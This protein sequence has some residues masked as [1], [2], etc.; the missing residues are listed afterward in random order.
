MA[1][2]KLTKTAILEGVWIGEL[3]GGEPGVR[4]ELE[5]THQDRPVPG[6]ELAPGQGDAGVWTLRIPI[7]ATVLT[8]GVQVVLI[9]DRKSGLCLDS[10]A[11][12]TGAPVEGD[13]RAEV[14]LLRDELDLLKR[15]FRR[16]CV[17]TSG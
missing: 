12:L 11:V 3:S 5:V 15:A 13:L 2:L 10:F 8:E 7:P 6:V 1:E 14:K 17:E 16:H 4:P 9:R